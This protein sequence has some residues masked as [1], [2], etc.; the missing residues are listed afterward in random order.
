MTAETHTDAEHDA[1]HAEMRAAVKALIFGEEKELFYSI[2]ARIGDK[3][4]VLTLGV[5]ARKPA[6]YTEILESVPGISRRMLT[7]TLRQ[8][9]RDGLIERIAHAEVPPWV[10]YAA[11]DLGR[12]L[13][14]PLLAVALWALEHR[15]AIAENR[16]VY[17]AT[18]AA[19]CDEK[20][21]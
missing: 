1:Q 6:R 18:I 12:T 10:E 2:L 4:S 14:E 20:K 13:K 19:D 17:D 8:L 5:L 9:E 7:V 16:K 11:T 21:R 15:E 3:W